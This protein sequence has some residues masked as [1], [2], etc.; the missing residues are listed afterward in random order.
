MTSPRLFKPPILKNNMSELQL[1]RVVMDIFRNTTYLA[2]LMD[3]PMIDER[4]L[5]RMLR[6]LYDRFRT[7]YGIEPIIELNR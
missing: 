2:L 1:Y 4:M 6:G 7:E 3:V 5:D